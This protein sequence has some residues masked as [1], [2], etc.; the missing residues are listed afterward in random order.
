MIQSQHTHV[1]HHPYEIEVM[2]SIAGRD[3]V[4]S[5]RGMGMGFVGGRRLRIE[6]WL[7]EWTVFLQRGLEV[8]EKEVRW[9]FVPGVGGMDIKERW[10]GA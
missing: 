6:M 5:G 4:S 2:P 9:G 8:W 3:I 7:G 10:R 1:H